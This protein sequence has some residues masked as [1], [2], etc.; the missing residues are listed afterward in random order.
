MI[1]YAKATFKL[2]FFIY[3]CA[4]LLKTQIMAL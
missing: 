3:F 1:C 2:D 4:F